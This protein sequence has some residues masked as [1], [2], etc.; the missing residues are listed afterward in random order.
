MFSPIDWGKIL[1]PDTPLLEM[2]LRGSAI[3]LSLF[4]LLR[5]TFKRE[6]GVFGIPNLLVLV[7]IADAAQN[8]MAGNYTSITDGLV[9]IGT[10]VAWSVALDWLGY[11]FPLLQRFVHPAPLLLVKD[12]RMLP[13]NLRRELITEEELMG[14]LKTEGVERLVN[15]KAAYIDQD[16]RIGVVT[17]KGHRRRSPGSGRA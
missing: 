3:Y 6:V 2:I 15:V 13:R 16:G 12:G 5:F 4:F 9:L 11:R 14:H 8:A 10:I 7:L 17:Y 1:I